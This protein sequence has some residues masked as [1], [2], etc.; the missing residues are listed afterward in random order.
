MNTKVIYTTTENKK[1][2]TI[3]FVEPVESKVFAE[4]NRRKHMAGIKEFS[5]KPTSKKTS[6]AKY[7][8]VEVK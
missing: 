3:L 6:Y 5:F 8:S 4:M 7:I 1:F 2:K